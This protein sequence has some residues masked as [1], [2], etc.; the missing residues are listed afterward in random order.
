MPVVTRRQ[1]KIQNTNIIE[2]V[3][4]DDIKYLIS[5]PW[6]KSNETHYNKI[7]KKLNEICPNTH[8]VA[9]IN[10]HV[11]LTKNNFNDCVS[12][13]QDTTNI[14]ILRMKEYCCHNNCDELFEKGLIKNIYTGY[15][16]SAD[17]KWRFH[18]GL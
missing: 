8:I 7:N 11:D 13:K 4:I 9:P 2:H 5:R 17:G 16:L 10:Y 6:Y 18:N 14:I 1:H 12:F 3:S 15:A